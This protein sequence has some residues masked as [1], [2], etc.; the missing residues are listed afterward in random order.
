MNIHFKFFAKN[1][2]NDKWN[3]VNKGE[4]TPTEANNSTPCRCRF[5][6]ISHLMYN[7]KSNNDILLLLLLLGR[8]ACIASMRPIAIDAACSVVCVCLCIWHTEV[9]CKNG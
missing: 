9:L 3:Y 2:K 5:R 8:M 4:Q 7:I 1:E 6:I